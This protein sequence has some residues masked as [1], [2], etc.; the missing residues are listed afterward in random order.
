M[1]LRLLTHAST[2]LSLGLLVLWP[3]SRRWGVS[4]RMPWDRQAFV[5]TNNGELIYWGSD[6]GYAPRWE[7][8]DAREQPMTAAW[9]E[10]EMGIGFAF[11][12][13]SFAFGRFDRNRI[14]PAGPWMTGGAWV[15]NTDTVAVVPIWFPAVLLAMPGV[16]RWRRQRG[17]RA[18]VGGFEVMPADRISSR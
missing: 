5:G 2:L 10:R 16:W 1:M 4:F 12:L 15:T 3:V 7:V 8:Y 14:I 9:I 6:W 13:R 11:R 17:R 18:T